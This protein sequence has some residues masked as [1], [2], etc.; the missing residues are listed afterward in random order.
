MI[1][2]KKQKIILGVQL[3]DFLN[4]KIILRFFLGGTIRHGAPKDR[5]ALII[6]LRTH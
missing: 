4:P 1:I 2:L 5:N 6:L 3:D